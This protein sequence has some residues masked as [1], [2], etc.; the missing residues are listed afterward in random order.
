M[1][2]FLPYADFDETARTLLERDLEQQIMHTVIALDCLHEKD[3]ETVAA[4]SKH[5]LMNMWR[6]YEVQLALYGQAMVTQAQIRGMD[7]DNYSKRLD[8]HYDT[9]TFPDDFKMEKPPWFDDPDK[10]RWVERSSRSL[11]VRRDSR[12]LTYWPGTS[13]NLT[14]Y[15]PS[16]SSVTE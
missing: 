10:M 7:V 6:G 14:P 9:A 16:V 1:Y 13:T 12:Y 3:A 2:T 15:Y 5:P 4:W 11:L 8:W